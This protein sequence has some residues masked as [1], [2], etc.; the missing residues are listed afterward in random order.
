MKAIAA[1]IWITTSVLLGLIVFSLGS[2]LIISQMQSGQ[3]ESAITQFLDLSS[4]VRRTCLTGGT[5]E[6][7]HYTISL[8]E[9][10]KAV[11]VANNSDDLPP[12]KV[13]EMI[14]NEKSAIGKYFCLQFSDENVPRCEQILCNTTFTYIGTPSLKQTVWSLLAKIQNPV[15]VYK[16]DMTINKTDMKWVVVSTT[17]NLTMPTS[18]TATTSTTITTSGETTTTTAAAGCDVSPQEL[19]SRVDVSEMKANLQELVKE[20]RYFGSQRDKDLADFILNKLKSYNLQ[21]PNKE[22]FTYDNIAGTNV[23]GEIGAGSSTV[24][25]VGG[26]RDSAGPSSCSSSICPGAVDNGAGASIVMEIGRVLSACKNAKTN[27]RFVLFDGE[28]VGE[29]GAYN[30]VDRHS[31]DNMIRMVNFDCEG[32]KGSS[33]L[34]AYRRAGDLATI[35]NDCCI[36]LGISC[37]IDDSFDYQSDHSAFLSKGIPYLWPC[38]SCNSL[39]TSDDNM[40]QI[41][42][43]QLKWGAQVGICVLAKAYLS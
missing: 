12:D 34:G 39:H 35:A 7:Y 1:W 42:D 37:D 36:L 5:G 24:V 8:P 14:T 23:V 6:L 20:Q 11:Y 32:Y 43:D 15:P 31:S 21:N 9:V 28:E 27:I 13:S 26:H 3:K 30:Y 17:G 19:A 33:S 22:D 4:K 25:V 18:P 16:F 38:T 2:S 41:G 29:V 40:S 10:V